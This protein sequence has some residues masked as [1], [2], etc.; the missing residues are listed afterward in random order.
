MF[1]LLLFIL[2]QGTV[3]TYFLRHVHKS[4]YVNKNLQSPF[5]CSQCPQKCIPIMGMPSIFISI[6]LGFGMQPILEKF[7]TF[8][9]VAWKSNGKKGR[10]EKLLKNASFPH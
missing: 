2:L 1:S 10:G 3:Q 4:V 9:L 7:F 6:L 5:E 8:G